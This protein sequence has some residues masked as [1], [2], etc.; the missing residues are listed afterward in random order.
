MSILIHPSYTN[1]RYILFIYLLFHH[2]I[3]TILFGLATRPHF[4]LILDPSE[5]FHSYNRSSRTHLASWIALPTNSPLSWALPPLLHPSHTYLS[6]E[7][8]S[9]QFPGP[10]YRPGSRVFWL[11]H[12]SHSI[13]GV[14]QDDTD[15]PLRIIGLNKAPMESYADVNYLRSQI[16]EIKND[17]YTPETIWTNWYKPSQGCYPIQHQLRTYPSTWEMTQTR[18]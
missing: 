8:F 7:P 3:H 9:L 12:K 2:K 10:D 15:P 16:Q 4:C 5:H 18:P 6:F 14:P 13:V 1:S 11:H 17:F